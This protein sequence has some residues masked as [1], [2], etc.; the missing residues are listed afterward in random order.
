MDFGTEC[1]RALLLELR[2]AV[3]VAVSELPCTHGVID[4]ELPGGG[5]RAELMRW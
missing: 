2:S 3:E 1:G 5:E 4:R